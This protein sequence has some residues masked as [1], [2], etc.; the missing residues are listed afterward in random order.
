MDRNVEREH[1]THEASTKGAKGTLHNLKEKIQHPFR[2]DMSSNSTY[3]SKQARDINEGTRNISGTTGTVGTTGQSLGSDLSGTSGTQQWDSGMGSGGTTGLG[4]T[5]G[6]VNQPG[7]V[8]GTY[9]TTGTGG[10]TRESTY[11]STTNRD[12]Y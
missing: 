9:P 3:E 4:S 2:H 12:R 6:G 7:S 11:S 1:G 5:L 10:T 8:S